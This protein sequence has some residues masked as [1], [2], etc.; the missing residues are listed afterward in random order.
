MASGEASQTSE[1]FSDS[2][3]HADNMSTFT[4]GGRPFRVIIA[5]AG[6]AGLVLSHAL[7]RA[8][9]EH[10]VLEKGVVAPEWG[11]SVSIWANGAR[12]LKQISCWDAL[13]AASSPLQKIYVRGSNGKAYSDE[14]Y[15]DMMLERYMNKI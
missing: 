11:A 12:I 14:P 4:K 8:G 3:L 15:F 10:I 13:L 2:P 1:S 7:E 6:V 9:I 5:G